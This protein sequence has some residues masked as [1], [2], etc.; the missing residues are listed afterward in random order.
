MTQR[1]RRRRKKPTISD[2]EAFAI[3]L[4]ATA[5]E[6]DGFIAITVANLALQERRAHKFN[7]C[8][9]RRGPYNRPKSEDFFRIIL[10]V[11]SESIFKAWFH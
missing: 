3:F 7:K 1:G 6:D 9:S 4:L 5:D 2:F 11:S 8:Y 10:D